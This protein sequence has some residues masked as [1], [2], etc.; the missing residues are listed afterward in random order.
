MSWDARSCGITNLSELAIAR[1]DG[2]QWR[3][4]GNGGT[5]GLTS[6]GTIIT[7]AAVT[8]FSPFTLA[9]TTSS[10][11]LPIELISFTGECNNQKVVLKWSTATEINNDYFTLE[12]SVDAINW[13]ITGSLQGSGN[14][15]VILHY[16]FAVAQPNKELAYYRLKQTDFSGEFKY[17]Q[18]ITIDKCQNDL[19]GSDLVIYPNPSTGFINLIYNGYKTQLV[20]IRIYN[21]MGEKIYDSAVYQSRIDMTNMSDG[22]YFIDFTSDSKSTIKKIVVMR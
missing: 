14:S 4:H 6:T 1:W 19:P 8:A 11:P 7:S 3:D 22:I 10:N 20:S 9:S 12:R 13:E 18:M 16:S 21:G 5:T 2:S 15:S 17:S